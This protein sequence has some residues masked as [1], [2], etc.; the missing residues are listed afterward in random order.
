M[1]VR[2]QITLDA[3]LQKRARER[4]AQL[5]I[6]LAEFVR[7]LV[8]RDLG[9]PPTA[10]DVSLICKLG[11]SGGSDVARHKDEML[12]AAVAEARTR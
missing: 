12:G 1:M 6:S 2:M 3:E 5:G 4:S 9:E 8:R 11:A 10:I 7:R